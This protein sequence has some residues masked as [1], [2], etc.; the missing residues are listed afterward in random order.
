MILVD[1]GKLSLDDPV[2]K[3]LPE[4]KG[5]KLNGKAPPVLPTVRHLLCNMSGLPAI[6]WRNRFSSG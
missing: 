3:F 4:F 6:F 1:K 2:E 5:I